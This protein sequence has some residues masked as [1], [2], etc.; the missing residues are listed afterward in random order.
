ME[1]LKRRF[2]HFALAAALVLFMAGT[3]SASS[4]D[5]P[6]WRGPNR[7]GI[8]TETGLLKKWP[9]VGPPLAW[10]ATGLGAGHSTV[11]ISKGRIFTAGDRGGGGLA[12]FGV[13]PRVGVMQGLLEEERGVRLESLR[14]RD[15]NLDRPSERGVVAHVRIH[16]EPDVLA[17]MLAHEGELV[18]LE[19]RRLAGSLADEPP[20]R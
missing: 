10:K 13:T 7:D 17:G 18:G 20:F 19:V 15:G 3:F 6:Q 11:S 9:D 2:D 4:S 5:W 8:S 16:H 1:I 12:E 14:D